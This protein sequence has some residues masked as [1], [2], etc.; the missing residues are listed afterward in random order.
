[1]VGGSNPNGYVEFTIK[2]TSEYRIEYLN[3][4][5]MTVPRPVLSNVPK[6]V[7]FNAQITFDIDIPSG[8]N[9]SDIQGK[10]L[11]SFS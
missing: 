4:P 3:P 11:S 1:M 7:D 10:H 5:Y 8:L 9:N 2:Y 6:Q